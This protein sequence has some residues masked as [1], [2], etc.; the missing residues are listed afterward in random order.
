MGHAN[1]GHANL[2][3]ANECSWPAPHRMQKFLTAKY[4]LHRPMMNEIKLVIVVSVIEI[5]EKWKILFYQKRWR[6]K[7][8]EKSGEHMKRKT[9]IN[10]KSDNLRSLSHTRISQ[11]GS[12]SIFRRKSEIESQR[13]AIEDDAHVV[14]TDSKNQKWA[15]KSSGNEWEA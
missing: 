2:G 5:P 6:R 9:G 11:W 8:R 14:Y 3:H 10:S 12:A 4:G 15:D 13:V 1:L 7:A